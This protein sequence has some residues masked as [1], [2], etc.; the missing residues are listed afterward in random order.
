VVLGLKTAL[1]LNMPDDPKESATKYGNTIDG[2]F[3]RDLTK[4]EIFIS[5]FSYHKPVVPDS[6]K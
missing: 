5:Y 1:D 4:F 3:L 6:S 2:V